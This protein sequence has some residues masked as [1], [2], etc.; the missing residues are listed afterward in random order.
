MLNAVCVFLYPDDLAWPDLTWQIR[1]GCDH[2]FFIKPISPSA[3]ITSFGTLIPNL[4]SKTSISK[5][6]WQH[7]R[8]ENFENAL[9]VK[10]SKCENHIKRGPKICKWWEDSKSGLKIQIG[11]DLTP[12]LAKNCRNW[13]NRIFCQFSAVFWAK[14]DILPI[15]DSFLGQKW[16]NLIRFE[17][18]GQTWN[19]LI[20]LHILGLRLI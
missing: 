9:E 12:F 19:P 8:F 10:K 6:N 20:I 4:T 5:E 16:S 11:L 18:W 15:F 3:I 13:L 17:F 1:A 2:H 14:S 7:V